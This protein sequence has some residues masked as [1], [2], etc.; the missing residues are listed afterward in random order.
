MHRKDECILELYLCLDV[1][2]GLERLKSST[3]TPMYQDFGGFISI[4]KTVMNLA[5][6][7][8]SSGFRFHF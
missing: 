3:K 4:K 1:L 6:F 7:S 8:T 5:I 2:V